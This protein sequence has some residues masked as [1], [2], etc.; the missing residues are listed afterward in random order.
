M[1]DPKN[2]KSKKSIYNAIGFSNADIDKIKGI[3]KKIGNTKIKDVPKH[4]KRIVKNVAKGAKEL[5]TVIKDE[6]KYQKNEDRKA[7]RKKVDKVRRKYRPND[8]DSKG[9]LKKNH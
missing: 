2:K 1:P 6:Y 3:S 5:Y 7:Y 9:K 4:T 8:Y